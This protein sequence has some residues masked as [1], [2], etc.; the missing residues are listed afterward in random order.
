MTAHI[1]NPL[2]DSVINQLT[3]IKSFTGDGAVGKSAEAVRLQLEA[4][5]EYLSASER[6]ALLPV[7]QIKS[8]VKAR[9]QNTR[10][11]SPSILKNAILKVLEREGEPLSLTI[12][13]ELVEAGADELGLD[14][15]LPNA[16]LRDVATSMMRE[17]L[18]IRRG[19]PF[20]FTFEPK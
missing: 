3:A 7:T 2:L 16:G 4:T 13:T 10:I 14:G 12:L 8:V 1:V 11:C 15:R 5:R 18:I 9:N 19:K 6:P 17:G 20:A